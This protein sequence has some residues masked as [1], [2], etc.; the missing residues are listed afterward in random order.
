MKAGIA[1]SGSPAQKSSCYQHYPNIPDELLLENDKV[2]VQR[3]VFP[4]GQWE[5]VHS[6][7][8]GQI[9]IPIKGG[10][11]TVRFGDRIQKGYSETGSVGW[12]GPV[13]LSADHESV[14]FGDEPIDLIWV[15]LKSECEKSKA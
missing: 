10:E 8:P 12:Y 7:P 3:F 13:E 15:T 2:V 5:A 9:Y 4:P 1:S 11:W 14:N 6:H